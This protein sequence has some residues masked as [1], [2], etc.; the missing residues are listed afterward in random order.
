MST[1]STRPVKTIRPPAH[2]RLGTFGQT[3]S[4][5]ALWIRP[6]WCQPRNVLLCRTVDLEHAQ[7]FTVLESWEQPIPHLDQLDACLRTDATRSE[8]GDG[9]F[10]AIRPI[11]PLS[12][13]AWAYAV[14]CPI[15]LDPIIDGQPWY[16]PCL[17]EG[18]IGIVILPRDTP[19]E[20]TPTDD[21][22]DAMAALDAAI[23]DGRA[24]AATAPLS[25][26]EDTIAPMATVAA[27]PQPEGI[28][29]P[30]DDSHTLIEWLPNGDT[31]RTVR[32]T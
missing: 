15:R 26:E 8:S 1:D 5:I 19:A 7:G 12:A 31:R 16:Q 10:D 23:Q 27:R 25:P 24:L 28:T 2:M 11:P 14:T 6:S 9:F 30:G 17:A 13:N 21:A 32:P 4:I 20:D 29:M 22:P 3:D 18:T